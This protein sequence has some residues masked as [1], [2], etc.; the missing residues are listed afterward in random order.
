MYVVASCIL[1]G[2]RIWEPF[3]TLCVEFYIYVCGHGLIFMHAVREHAWSKSSKV[4]HNKVDH[5]L[6]QISNLIKC[7]SYD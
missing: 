3:Y 2:S 1:I 6:M 5:K 7:A 4:K